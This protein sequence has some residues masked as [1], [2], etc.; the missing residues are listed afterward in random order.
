MSLEEKKL[1]MH[2]AKVYAARIELEY[3]LEQRREEIKNI[4]KN[5]DLQLKEEER[6]KSSING[7]K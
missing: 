4:E 6:L 3:R 5:I 2:L 7:S 1:E